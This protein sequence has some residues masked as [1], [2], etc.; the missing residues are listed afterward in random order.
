LQYAKAAGKTSKATDLE[1]SL[2]QLI[3]DRSFLAGREEIRD[4]QTFEQRLLSGKDQLVEIAE[5]TVD[6]VGL[7]LDQYQKVRSAL[8]KA[9]Q[10][11][12]LD[13]IRDMQ[14]Q[15][16]NLLFQGFLGATDYENLGQYPRYLKAMTLRLEKL[17]HAASRDQQKMREM[18][19]LYTDW[20]QRYSRNP[21]DNRLQE[22]RWMFEEMRVSLFA[23]E[24]KTAYPISIKRIEKRWREMGL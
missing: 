21:G 3:I 23:Q 19:N 5:Q 9:S 11:N 22:I 10:I 1:Q 7:V 13:S 4:Q 12:W 6:L 18:G 15:L 2:I 17:A 14:Q 8:S 16:D 24:L 20:Q